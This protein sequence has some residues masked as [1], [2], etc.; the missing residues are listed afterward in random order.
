MTLS[1][2]IATQRTR[3]TSSG[4]AGGEAQ[5]LVREILF[6]LKGYSNT[7][8]AYHA[9]DEV[10]GYL[11]RHT[12]DA[13]RRVISGEP[14]QYIFG[15]AHFHGME[16]HV[17]PDVLI[18]RPETSELV[19]LIADHYRDTADLRVM[20]ICTGSGC[21]AIALSR[22]LKFARISAIDI[23]EAALSIARQNASDLKANVDFSL[24]DILATDQASGQYDIIVSNPPYICES[25]KSGMEKNVLDHEPHTAL[26]V[27]D[28]DPLLFYRHI[29]LYARRSLTGCGTLWLEINPMHADALRRMLDADGWNDINL[30][31]DTSG[32]ERFTFARQ[33]SR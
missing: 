32:R 4:I 22:E 15:M 9:S 14:V 23:S 13:V 33:P 12:A 30:I 19:D 25:E 20:D 29:S 10:T 31:R 21:I 27:P 17:S 6:R 16:L 28:S 5:A 18:P 8:I 2:L 24:M 26:F 3:L 7:D 11:S 1:Q